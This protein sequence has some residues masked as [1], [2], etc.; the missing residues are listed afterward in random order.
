MMIH[1]MFP[2]V[3]SQGFLPC[4]QVVSW[5]SAQGWIACGGESGLLKA[6]PWGHGSGGQSFPGA[7]RFTMAQR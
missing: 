2:T 1:A 6:G 5:N 3:G 4:S 7:Q